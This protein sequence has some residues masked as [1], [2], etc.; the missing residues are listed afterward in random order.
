MNSTGGA[1][2]NTKFRVLNPWALIDYPRSFPQVYVLCS[3]DARPVGFLQLVLALPPELRDQ[4]EQ[5]RYTGQ[6]SDGL[7]IIHSSCDRVRN[8][9]KAT[10]LFSD[11]VLGPVLAIASEL[12]VH[13][14]YLQQ[15]RYYFPT[16]LIGELGLANVQETKAI[17]SASPSYAVMAEVQACISQVR[18]APSDLAPGAI[19]TMWNGCPPMKKI[20]LMKRFQ[21]EPTLFWSQKYRDHFVHT[22]KVFLLGQNHPTCP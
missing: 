18:S 7:N 8:I 17:Y 10:C 16:R 6:Y 2:I 12:K 20:P 3:R 11:I 21:A 19:Q 15:Q 14:Q 1:S 9:V 4:A 5:L 13:H 22:L